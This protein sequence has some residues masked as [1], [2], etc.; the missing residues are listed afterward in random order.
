METYRRVIW[1][2]G[3]SRGKRV[4]LGW[5]SWQQATIIEVGTSLTDPQAK[6]REQIGNRMVLKPQRLSPSDILPPGKTTPSKPCQMWQHLGWVGI[7]M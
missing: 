2:Y 5:V 6:Q 4:H 1:S 3:G 7:Q